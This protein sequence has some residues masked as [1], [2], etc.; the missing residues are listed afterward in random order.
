MPYDLPPQ[1]AERAEQAFE[2]LLKQGLTPT[3]EILHRLLDCQ[4]RQGAC[5]CVRVCVCACV[6]VGSC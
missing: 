6:R 2:D 5:V 3:K 1:Y 4:A